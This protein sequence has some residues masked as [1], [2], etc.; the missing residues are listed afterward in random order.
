MML[1]H[2]D[3]ILQLVFLQLLQYREF[4]Y[5]YFCILLLNELEHYLELMFLS[6]S[7]HF[8]L[9]FHDWSADALSDLG[10]KSKVWEAFADLLVKIFLLIKYPL[11]VTLVVNVVGCASFE[12]VPLISCSRY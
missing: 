12:K 3:D 6:F 1:D 5:S 8:L 10:D 4:F 2:C 11:E 7:D 9:S